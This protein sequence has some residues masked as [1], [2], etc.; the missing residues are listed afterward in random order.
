MAPNRKIAI[1]HSA[2]F[3]FLDAIPAKA[4]ADPAKPIEILAS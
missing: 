2:T 4:I 1:P 3:E